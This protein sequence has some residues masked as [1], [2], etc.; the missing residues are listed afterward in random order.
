MEDKQGGVGLSLNKT[1][2]E[3]V[4]GEPAIPSTGHLLQPV[5][6]LVGVTDPIR[7]CGINKPHRLATADY[8]REGAMQE[9]VLHIEL[10]NRPGAQDN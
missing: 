2:T 3:E 4:S 7:L 6:R 1:Q 8:L 5:E 10:M 9:R